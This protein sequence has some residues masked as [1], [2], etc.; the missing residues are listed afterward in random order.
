MTFDV[1]LVGGGLQNALLALA[2]VD[3]DPEVSMAIVEREG[4]LGGNHTWSFHD[5]DVSPRM[6]KLLAPAV[7]HRW[8]SWRVKFP[9]LE[10]TVARGYATMTSSSLAKVMADALA[11]APNVKLLLGCEAQE[12]GAR[13]VTLTDGRMLL[14]KRVFDARGPGRGMGRVDAVQKFLGL[15]LALKTP[16]ALTEPL[17]MDVTVPQED[18]YRFMYLLPLSPTREL[19]EDTYYSDSP[20][21]DLEALRGK[22]RAYAEAAGLDVAHVVREEHG[23]LPL[24]LTLEEVLAAQTDEGPFRAGYGGGWFHPTTGYSLPCAARLAEGVAR[25]LHSPRLREE[26]DAHWAAH[27][28][29]VRFFVLLNRL[30]FRAFPPHERWRALERFHRLPEETIA[31]FYSLELSAA[32]RAR[33]LVGR[34]P[35]RIWLGRAFKEIAG[36]ASW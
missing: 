15:E 8:P 17:L 1:I 12:V 26:V 23:V 20:A 31:R 33:V 24:P 32:D 4:A 35:A 29:Q 6:A 16:H 34:P 10:R 3:A 36:A 2:L 30:M 14:G 18:G 28:R 13:S 7:A 11:R 9:N 25:D 19:V 27:L 22:V 5:G 21:L